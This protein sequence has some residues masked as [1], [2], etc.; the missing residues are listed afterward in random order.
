MQGR[1]SNSKCSFQEALVYIE[2]E[3]NMYNFASLQYSG[4]VTAGDGRC[5]LY[6]DAF[7]LETFSHS[8]EGR[9]EFNQ[10]NENLRYA[11]CHSQPFLCQ[12]IDAG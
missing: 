8:M 4:R 6:H 3:Q 9:A 5:D 1:Q 2:P 11:L 12:T 10:I 7:K